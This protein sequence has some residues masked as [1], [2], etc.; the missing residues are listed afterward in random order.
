[1]AENVNIQYKLEDE[2]NSIKSV[3]N[4]I[5]KC[6]PSFPQNTKHKKITIKNSGKDLRKYGFVQL[7]LFCLKGISNVNF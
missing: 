4:L 6:P 2:L 3:F 7:I 5:T 1:M